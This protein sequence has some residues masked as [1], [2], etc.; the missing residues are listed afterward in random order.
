MPGEGRAGFAHCTRF[1]MCG[2]LFVSQAKKRPGY[3]CD[4]GCCLAKGPILLYIR[5]FYLFKSSVPDR[6]NVCIK[7]KKYLA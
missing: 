1:N 4:N 7:N 3:S 5:D 2:L 6:V